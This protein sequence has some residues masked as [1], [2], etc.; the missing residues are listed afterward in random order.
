MDVVWEKSPKA[1]RRFGLLEACDHIFCLA[2]IREWRSTKTA[3]NTAIRG[4]PECRTPSNFVIPSEYFVKDE[5]KQALIDNYKTALSQKHCMH[6][7][8]GNGECPFGISC[9]Y[10]HMYDDGTLQDRSLERLR[11]NANGQLIDL[12]PSHPLFELLRDELEEGG[13]LHDWQREQRSLRNQP[14]ASAA[15]DELNEILDGLLEAGVPTTEESEYDEED[16]EDDQI[17]NFY[18]D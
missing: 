12:A 5:L 10:K 2:C 6:F 1:Q 15:L 18:V 17:G 4:C 11:Y 16:Y 7:K 3:D 8:R 9:F 13:R 14:Y